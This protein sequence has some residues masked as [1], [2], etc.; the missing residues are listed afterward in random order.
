MRKG[1]QQ[2]PKGYILNDYRISE[3]IGGGGFSLVYR[4]YHIVSRAKVVIKEYYPT[5][6]TYRLP[7]GR[8]MPV[9]DD[10]EREYNIGI[11]RFFDEAHA[12]AKVNHPNIVNVSNVFR[13]NNS[14]YM[15]MDYKQGPDLRAYIKRHSGALSEKFLRTVFPQVLI[16]LRALHNRNLL[17][18]DVK[19]ANILIRPGGRPLLIDFG[20]VQ[21]YT[22]NEKSARTQTLTIGYA[23][24][25]QHEKGYLGPWTDLYGIGATM[26]S[27]I[28]GT[29]PPPATDRL[30]RDRIS[31]TTER[32]SRRYSQELLEAIEWCL[33]VDGDDRPQSVNELLECCFADDE[34]EE[35]STPLPAEANSRWRLPLAW[36]RSRS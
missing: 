5:D 33:Q 20:A 17:H 22:E 23:S 16:G 9:S 24:I 32:W 29:P 15:V 2:L 14:V 30:A 19:P 6:I 34:E 1:K 12:L 7:G 11:K 13:A 35:T 27:C 36:L 3:V 4:A 25:E 18:L 10:K 8:I 26:Y 31:P 21:R 28:A